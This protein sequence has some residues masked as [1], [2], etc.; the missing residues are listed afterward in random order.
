MSII[1]ITGEMNQFAGINT[2]AIHVSLYA[3]P[4]CD[5]RLYGAR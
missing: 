4:A 1:M 5:Y 3:A 2:S